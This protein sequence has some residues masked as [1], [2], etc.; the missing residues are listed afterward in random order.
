MRINL[1]QCLGLA[2]LLLLL[3]ACST[4]PPF[5]VP[6]DN[7]PLAGVRDN[8]A[9]YQ[10][11]EVSWGGVI[12]ETEVKQNLSIVTILAKPLDSQGEPIETDQSYG[13]FLAKFNDFR[14]PAIFAAGRSLTVSGVIL[15]SQTRKIGDYDYVHPLIAVTNYRL[16]PI[17]Q[18][19]PYYDNYWYDPWYPWGPWYYPPMYYYPRTIDSIRK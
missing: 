3:A 6:A 10:N 9:A 11:K 4:V 18:P 15:G 1:I 17:R 5:P 16:W 8:L 14:D 19:E 2:G 12:L 13:R 7:P